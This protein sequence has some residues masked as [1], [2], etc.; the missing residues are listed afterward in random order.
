MANMGIVID[1]WAT[2]VKSN[3]WWICRGKVFDFFG[4]SIVEFHR[5]IIT[6]K[7]KNSVNIV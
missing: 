6:K 5:V 3:D 7:C 4:K 1:G 2:A